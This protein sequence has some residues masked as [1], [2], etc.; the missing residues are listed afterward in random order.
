MRTSG[1]AGEPGSQTGKSRFYETVKGKIIEYSSELFLS[2]IVFVSGVGAYQANKAVLGLTAVSDRI[3]QIEAAAATIKIDALR[4]EAAVQNIGEL[5]NLHAMLKESFRQVDTN[6]NRLMGELGRYH[7]GV[8]QHYITQ[9]VK[10]DEQKLKLQ[11]LEQ[12]LEKISTSINSIDKILFQA[13]QYATVIESTNMQLARE[14]SV[15]NKHFNNNRLANQ[16]RNAPAN[17]GK[18]FT[19]EHKSTGSGEQ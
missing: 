4:I 12:Q 14:I 3:R 7:E 5:A 18:L 16:G 13:S 9:R 15:L 1:Q 8:W 10:D 6:Q 2:V 11:L 19:I 17:T